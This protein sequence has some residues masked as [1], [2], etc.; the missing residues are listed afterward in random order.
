MKAVRD[1]DLPDSKH[2]S[3]RALCVQLSKRTQLSAL[4]DGIERVE[5]VQDFGIRTY[6][7][8]AVRDQA[9]GADPG[10]GLGRSPLCTQGG[11]PRARLPGLTAMMAPSAAAQ[12]TRCAECDLK[13]ADTRR[14][15]YGRSREALNDWRCDPQF[16]YA[17]SRRLCW[18]GDSTAARGARSLTPI[19]DAGIAIASQRILRPALFLRAALRWAPAARGHAPPRS[20]A[21]RLPRPRHRYDHRPA[22]MYG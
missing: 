19:G 13:A 2:T 18:E 6:A 5:R 16:G 3:S 10:F 9:R 1:S 4:G 14:R 15:H 20:R 11:M 7:D 8:D 12:A 17:P 22:V 21:Q